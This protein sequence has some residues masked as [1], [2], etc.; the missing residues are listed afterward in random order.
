[1][2]VSTVSHRFCFTFCVR[3]LQIHNTQELFP[4]VYPRLFVSANIKKLSTIISWNFFCLYERTEKQHSAN[5]ETRTFSFT[6]L[7]NSNNKSR[8]CCCD[9]GLRHKTFSV[10]EMFLLFLVCT[11]TKIQQNISKIIVSRLKG[12]LIRL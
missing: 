3:R 9:L 5:M 1:M 8:A 4:W 6:F 7:H 2:L 11:D 10:V 12:G